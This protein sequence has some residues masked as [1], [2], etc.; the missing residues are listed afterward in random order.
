MLY[1]CQYTAYQNCAV[2]YKQIHNN[3]VSAF[4]N[5]NHMTQNW[6]YKTNWTV[7]DMSINCCLYTSMQPWSCSHTYPV[8]LPKAA[9]MENWMERLKI[10]FKVGFVHCRNL[11]CWCSSA[12]GGKDSLRN[13]LHNNSVMATVD[14]SLSTGWDQLTCVTLRFTGLYRFIQPHVVWGIISACHPY[15]V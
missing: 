15:P 14:C 8:E 7:R 4:N 12:A 9:V 3:D 13:K 5:Q 11:K 1:S 10:G 6:W 2:R